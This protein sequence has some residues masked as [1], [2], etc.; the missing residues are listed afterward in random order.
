MSKDIDEL[1]RLAEQEVSANKNV[2]VNP[3]K[4]HNAIISKDGIEEVRRFI[5]SLD[6]KAGRTKCTSRAIYDV[7]KKWSD[8]PM[9]KNK[10]FFEFS[11]WFIPERK[12]TYR[13]Y[14]L[15]MAIIQYDWKVRDLK[16]GKK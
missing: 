6:I 11:K 9:N 14:R 8:A 12:V 13:F 3:E 15:E 2:Q 1:I 16:K 4:L 10:F 7:Y 5:L